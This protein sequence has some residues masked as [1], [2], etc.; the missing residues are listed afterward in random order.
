MN[1]ATKWTRFVLPSQEQETDRAGSGHSN[2]SRGGL[3]SL[4]DTAGC[5]LR[6]RLR[7]AGLHQVCR[8]SE[9]RK[10]VKK[11]IGQKKFGNRERDDRNR[12]KLL[13]MGWRVEEIWEFEVTDEHKLLTCSPKG[14]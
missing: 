6:A 11:H 2:H 3:P 4:S 5:G 7:L 12:K 13:D 10:I 1:R 9:G 14:P 8:W